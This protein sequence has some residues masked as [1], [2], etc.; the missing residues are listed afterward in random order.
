MPY[1]NCWATTAIETLNKYELKLEQI[2]LLS[3]S[4]IKQAIHSKIEETIQQKKSTMTKLRFVSD[5]GQWYVKKW[6][7]QD[8]KEM[9]SFRLD[10]WAETSYVSSE[11]K[12]P[13]CQE[14]NFTIEHLV[15]C[16]NRIPNVDIKEPNKKNLRLLREVKVYLKYISAPTTLE[17]LYA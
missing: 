4:K 1:K 10:T 7:L 13:K 11:M 9:M 2:S 8:I 3:K 14:R 5:F 17:C 16:V 12:C 15:I 6:G